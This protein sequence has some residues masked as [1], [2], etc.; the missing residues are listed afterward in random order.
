MPVE[1]SIGLSGIFNL[2]TLGNPYS[3][4]ELSSEPNQL[5]PELGKLVSSLDLLHLK[6]FSDSENTRKLSRHEKIQQR[7]L[8][9]LSANASSTSTIEPDKVIFNHSS[10][11]LTEQEKTVLAEGLNFSIPPKTLNY[12][13]FLIPFELLHRQIQQETI[14]PESGCDKDFVK[15]KLKDIALSGFRNYT[16][17]PFIFSDEKFKMLKCLRNDDSK[18]FSSYFFLFD[19]L[20]GSDY[21]LESRKLLVLSWTRLITA[22]SLVFT[23]LITQSITINHNFLLTIISHTLLT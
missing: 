2:C 20:S 1:E 15:T 6:S 22:Q 23:T 7:K 19:I 10:R 12:C 5:H 18:N 4:R 14:Y 11:T 3:I 9:R 17:P 21:F 16:P 13:D 8:F